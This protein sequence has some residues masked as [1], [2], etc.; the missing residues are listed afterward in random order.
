MDNNIKEQL[1][2]REQ[3]FSEYACRYSEAIRLNGDLTDDFRPDFDRDIDRIMNT[4]SYTRYMD[5]T[6]VFSGTTND[7]ISKRIIHVQLVSRVA[8]TIGR[9]LGLNEDLIEAAALGHDIGHVPFGHVGESYLNELSLKYDNTYFM[10][11][12][13]SVRALNF[14]E[15]NGAGKNLTIQVLDGILCHNGEIV[16]NKYQPVKKTKEDFIRDYELCYT[17]PNHS[18]ELK[19][20]TLEGCVVRISDVIAYLGRD[21]E[22]AIELGLLDKSIIPESIQKILGNSNSSIIDAI[23][24]DVIRESKGKPYISMSKEIYQAIEDLKKFNYEYIYKPAMDEE[25]RTRVKEMFI[26]LF[27]TYLDDLNKG[28][29]DSMIYQD[30]LN[31]MNDSYNNNTSNTR[32]V[33]DYIAGMTD[34]YM[35]RQDTIIKARKK[36]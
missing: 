9:C 5:K 23:V 25:E 8:R 35:Q 2:K 31:K 7:H 12:V 16:E 10:H 13:E 6:Q 3:E 22:D 27:E 33:I 4:L 11:N 26:L 14:L 17:D 29:Y 18:K 36:M 1:L 19:P 24:N 21:I 15:K 34:D 20:M 32:K 28:N 30:F